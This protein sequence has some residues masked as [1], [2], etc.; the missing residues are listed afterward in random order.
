MKINL[1]ILQQ[2]TPNSLWL[3]FSETEIKQARSILGQHSNQ[4]EKIKHL[5]II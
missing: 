4:T 5:L 1:N 3:T 2:I